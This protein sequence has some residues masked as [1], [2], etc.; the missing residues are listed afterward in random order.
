MFPLVDQRKYGSYTR[1]RNFLVRLRSVIYVTTLNRRNSLTF[2]HLSKR[3]TFTKFYRLCLEI[4]C[5]K[6]KKKRKKNRN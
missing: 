6:K 1:T 2:C 3:R 4:F 5:K